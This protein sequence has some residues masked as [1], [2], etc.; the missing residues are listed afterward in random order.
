MV[1]VTPRPAKVSSVSLVLL[2]QNAPQQSISGKEFVLAPGSRVQVIT[3]GRLRQVV[4]MHP[5]EVGE[6]NVTLSFISPFHSI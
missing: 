3:A 4:A 2:W 6:V 5:Q 1:R